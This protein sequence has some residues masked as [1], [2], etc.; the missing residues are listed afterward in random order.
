MDLIT[1]PYWWEGGAPL[2]EIDPT[3]PR[4]VD[5]AVVGGGFTGMSA[6]LTAAEAGA[7]VLVLDAEEPGKGASTRNGGMIG[8]P[9]RPEL[10]ARLE[11]ADPGEAA[12]L[13]REGVEAYAHT[14]ALYTECGI[15]A[16]YQQTGRIHLSYTGAHFEALK[17]QVK[18]LNGLVDQ[19]VRILE[20]EELP[21]H[22]R[23]DLYF[24]G[25]LFPDHGGVHPRRAHDGF[26]RLALDAGARVAAPCA[27]EAVARDGDG[28]RL[29]TSH[30]AVAARRV[31]FATNGYT[32]PAWR[33]LSRR[34]F[35]IPSYIVATAPLPP[36]VI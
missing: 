27:V 3:P 4:R 21:Q 24:G 34:I 8:A 9:H 31:V 19:G 25:A 6:A 32:T 36:E 1:T 11:T 28:F 26:L 12:P 20:R 15:D 16:G 35:R 22:I 13:I 30:G 18:V 14:R 33:W 17:R 5:L 7:E 23:T 10:L 29:T 2:P